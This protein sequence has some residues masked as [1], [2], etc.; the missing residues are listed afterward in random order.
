[1]SS[2]KALLNAKSLA[3][4]RRVQ[5]AASIAELYL[6]AIR[7]TT[8]ST[9]IEDHASFRYQNQAA[10]PKYFGFHCEITG[11]KLKFENHYVARG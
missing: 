5:P 2:S 1:V 7:A 11:D 9:M 8:R 10:Q 3:A 6:G 4:K